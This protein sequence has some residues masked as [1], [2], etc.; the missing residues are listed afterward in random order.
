MAVESRTFT[1]AER[2]IHRPKPGHDNATPSGNGVAA[3]ALNRLSFLTGENRFR[4]AAEDTLGLFWPAMRKG[5]AGY[6]SLLAALAETLVPPRTVIVN[7]PA[8][9]LPPWRDGLRREY[10]PDSLVLLVPGDTR[11]LPPPLAKPAGPQVNAWV[12]E[13]VTC[14]RPILEPFQLHETL[15]ASRIARFS[16]TRPSGD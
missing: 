14:M 1:D 8:A 5:P 3:W 11:E 4:Q 7:G 10:L 9:A 2:L 12:C 6:G 13:G 16:K 15:I